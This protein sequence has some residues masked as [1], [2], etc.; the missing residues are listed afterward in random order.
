MGTT[1][2][3]VKTAV[4]GCGM[5]SN[6]YIRNLKNL[7]SIIDLTALCDINPEAAEQKAK[8]YGV[9]KIMTL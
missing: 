7:F 1:L 8:S 4:V 3:K 6:I 9:E 2:K 5:I